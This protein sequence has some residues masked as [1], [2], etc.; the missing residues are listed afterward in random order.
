MCVFEN[1]K[2]MLNIIAIVLLLIGGIY[3][4]LFVFNIT[5]LAP[6]DTLLNFKISNV[7]YIL[8]FLSALYLMLKR[9]TYLPFLGETA[10][11]SGLLLKN[12]TP[13][14]ANTRVTINTKPNSKI[15]YW[16]ADKDGKYDYKIAYGDY[17]NAGVT[18]SD[19]LGNAVLF[20]R[21]PVS[22][23]VPLSKALEPHV[24][25]RVVD[26]LKSGLIGRVET[27]KI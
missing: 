2:I 1:N 21:K 5:P 11:P 13:E 15:V 9:D 18:E 16:A 17:T 19:A 12:I 24:H 27:I 26:N 14:N 10:F 6:L 7:V 23:T 22:Y 8:V 25:Y 20:L 4:G 3:W